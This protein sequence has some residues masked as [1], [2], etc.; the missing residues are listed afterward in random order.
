MGTSLAPARALTT[1]SSSR[2]IRSSNTRECP[3]PFVSF[4]LELDVCAGS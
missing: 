4:E 3:I 1:S 2:V